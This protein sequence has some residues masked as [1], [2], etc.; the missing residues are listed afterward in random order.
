MIA[1]AFLL[2]AQDERALHAR[3]SGQ[4]RPV[5]NFIERRAGCNHFAGEEP[6]DA[7]RSL[8]LARQMRRL[9]CATL[10]RDEAAL[11]RRY[12]ARSDT[13]S[14][15]DETVEMSGFDRAQPRR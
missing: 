8:F 9:R 13:A 5:I 4:P 12:R 14:V 15:L 11:R 2:L 6:Y 3:I 10:E 1:V 7:E